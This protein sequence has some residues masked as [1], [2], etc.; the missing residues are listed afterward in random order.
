M[1]HP[2][3]VHELL[4]LAELDDFETFCREP[5]RTID[6]AHDWL[7]ERGFTLSRGAVYNWKAKFD[8]RVMA[9]RFSRSGELARAMKSAMK[10]GSFEDVADAAAMQLT[11]VVFEQ[12]SRLEAEGEVD[13]L[14]V[15]RMT[16]S[17]NNLAALRDALRQLK[18]RQTAAI[19]AAEK[20]A[21]A[22][23]SSAAV[24]AKVREI[25]GIA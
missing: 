12:S 11:Q 1:S 13:S 2:H 22:G 6:E 7:L 4:S 19:E 15:V 3:K 16:K 20:T 25:L 10:D 17:L 8:E 23:G 18:E 9:D 21:K 5:G 24:V 14:D